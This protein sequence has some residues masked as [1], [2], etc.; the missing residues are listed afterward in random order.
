MTL[1]ICL[2]Q[3]QGW[4]TNIAIRKLYIEL[5]Y[6]LKEICRIQLFQVFCFFITS[7]NVAKN[8]FYEY[9]YGFFWCN[10]QQHMM[11]CL[12]WQL[13]SFAYWK[14]NFAY[15]A[16]LTEGESTLPQFSVNG[17]GETLFPRHECIDTDVK[18]SYSQPNFSRSYSYNLF[19]TLQS[20]LECLLLHN[21]IHWRKR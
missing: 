18:I 11:K 19:C 17:F 21:S 15:F 1:F 5:Y 3:E 2:L 12:W 4:K 7:N 14:A 6:K 9:N 13:F 8:H 16:P 20:L 10:S